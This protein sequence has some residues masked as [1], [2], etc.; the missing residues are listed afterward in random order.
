MILRHCGG[1]TDGMGNFR[2]SLFGH[3]KIIEYCNRP[4]DS[5]HQM[6]EEMIARWN[7]VV[8]PEDTV[9]HLGD[10]AFFRGGPDVLKDITRRLNGRKILVSGNH[11]KRPG[12]MR[13]GGF[14]EVYEDQLVIDRDDTKLL[15]SHKRISSMP[16]LNVSVELWNYYPIPLPTVISQPLHLCGHTHDLWTI[17]TS[18]MTS[19]ETEL[20]KDSIKIWRR[21]EERSDQNL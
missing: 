9:Y 20:A 15:L 13:E 8:K 2:P 19:T 12:C 3:E 6:D 7:A 4:F 16:T 18:Y 21:M 10:F 5:V 17:N 1:D 14:D 11:D